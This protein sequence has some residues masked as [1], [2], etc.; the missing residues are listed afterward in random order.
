MKKKKRNTVDLR[1]LGFFWLNYAGWSIVCLLVCSYVRLFVHFN[2]ILSVLNLIFV[3]VV[4]G[5][6]VF[7][8]L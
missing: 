8:V 7:G 5:F 2:Q 4:V 1:L 6:V 3:V